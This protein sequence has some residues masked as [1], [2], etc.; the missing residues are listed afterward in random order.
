MH[1]VPPLFSSRKVLS[2]RRRP[3]VVSRLVPSLTASLKPLAL[4][5]VLRRF[6]N[7]R[8]A[9]IILHSLTCFRRSP[10]FRA[11]FTP[12]HNLSFPSARAHA[13]S[14]WPVFPHPLRP[15][16][17]DEPSCAG[18]ARS[19]KAS[20]RNTG[21]LDACTSMRLDTRMCAHIHRTN[22]PLGFVSPI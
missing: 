12:F 1:T 20:L 21:T 8:L 3:W 2:K 7:S 14:L 5:S 11:R 13:L 17:T 22:E 9:L 18:L 15:S 19:N 6:I 10:V 16:S 4:R